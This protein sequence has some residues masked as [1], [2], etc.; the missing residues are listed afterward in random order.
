[1]DTDTNFTSLMVGGVLK[2]Q[3]FYGF[4]VLKMGI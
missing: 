2:T 1:M 3:L 4:G